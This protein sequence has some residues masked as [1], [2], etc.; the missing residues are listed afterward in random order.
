MDEQTKVIVSVVDYFFI[1]DMDER[2]KISYPFR[3][4]FYI[5]T[6]NG[7]EFQVSSYLS[8][9]YGSATT[10]EHMDKEDLDLVS[11]AET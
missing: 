3:P 1:S 4:Y 10:V 9:K 11:D 8:K 2:F 6:I 5:A 7:F